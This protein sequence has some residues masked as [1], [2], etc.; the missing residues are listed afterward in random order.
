MYINGVSYPVDVPSV[1]LMNIPLGATMLVGAYYNPTGEWTIVQTY[2]NASTVSFYYN[3]TYTFAFSVWVGLE[4]NFFPGN[5]GFWWLNGDFELTVDISSVPNYQYIDAFWDVYEYYICSPTCHLTIEN[6]VFYESSLSYSYQDCLGSL[7]NWTTPWYFPLGAVITLSI[8]DYEFGGLP[9]VYVTGTGVGSFTGQIGETLVCGDYFNGYC[10]YYYYVLGA[11]PISTN[12]PIQETIWLGDAPENLSSNVTFSSAGLPS[13]STFHATFNGSVLSGTPAA[14]AVV[15]DVAAG[16]YSVSDV[17]ATSSTPGWE[18]FGAAE[19]PNPFVP[20]LDTSVTLAFDAFVNVAAPAG[21]VSFHAP[22]I[23]AGTTWSLT[24]NG[25]TYTSHTPWINLTTRP[26]TFAYSVGDAVA[27]S[28]TAGYVPTTPSGNESVVPGSTYT[29]DYTPAFEVLVAASAGGLVSVNHGS[30]QS[31]EKQ[32]W[33]AGTVLSL[34]ETASSGY[35]FAGWTGTGAGAYNGTSPSTSVT[36]SGPIVETASYLP[37]PGARFNLTFVES[38]VPSGTWWT[39]NLDGIG[40]SSDVP[41]MTVSGLYSWSSG[42]QGHYNLTVPT[43]YANGTSLTK[44]V[45]VLFPSVVGANGTLTA[46]VNVV[47]VPEEQVNLALS[48]D[49]TVSSTYN[50]APSGTSVWA[51]QGSSVQITATAYPGWTFSGWEGIGSGSYTGPNATYDVTANGPINEVALFTQVVVQQAPTYT[52][53]FSLGTP[54]ATGTTW[55]VTLGGLGYSTTASTLVVTDVSATTYALQVNTATAPS[56]LAQYRAT[57]S[58]PVALTVRSN[59]TISVSYDPYYFVAV[60]ASVGGTVSPG[61]GWYASGSVLYLVAAANSS[62]TFA[63]WAGSGTGSYTGGNAT[64]SVI[65]TGPITEV[66]TFQSNHVGAA[67]T[68]IWSNPATWAGFGGAA[69]VIGIAIGAIVSWFANR[70]T[71]A[72]GR[73][74]GNTRASSP[75]PPG[76]A[77]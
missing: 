8:E 72:G 47:F 70:D 26:G 38:G 74:Q 41:S 59:V 20:P 73:P 61:A 35:S 25:T 11:G 29:I 52:V 2:F 56:G 4:F 54:I 51:V 23:G 5:L 14:P 60:S 48:G 76:G 69:L 44:Y 75:P 3:Q 32:F 28:G 7:C 58:D 42:I 46:P 10:Y 64:A 19:G 16:A 9:A 33:A 68:S 6:E 1:I 13:G 40:Y 63:S 66:A 22:A 27:P 12:G 77:Q 55:G 31:S 30:Q 36:V 39:V 34:T 21:P 71:P 50:K 24:F 67:G 18:Y 37:L 65:V 62:D 57:S 17:W 45:A 43:S 49:G 53:T 15:N